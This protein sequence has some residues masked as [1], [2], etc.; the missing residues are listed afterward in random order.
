MKG[1]HHLLPVAERLI[2]LGVCGEATIEKR[3]RFFRVAVTEE[4]DDSAAQRKVNEAPAH[5]GVIEPP[6]FKED[7]VYSFDISEVSLSLTKKVH[8]MVVAPSEPEAAPAATVVKIRGVVNHGRPTESLPE[9]TTRGNRDLSGKG[10]V[11]ERVHA[12]E[13]LGRQAAGRPTREVL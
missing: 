13:R 10:R 1:P 6:Q 7:A 12:R 2:E 8:R 3:F 9:P 11:R 4:A 5:D